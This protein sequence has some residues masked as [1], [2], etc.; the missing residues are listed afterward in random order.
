[1]RFVSLHSRRPCTFLGVHLEN[2]KGARRTMRSKTT[3]VPTTQARGMLPRNY[4]TLGV[5]EGGYQAFGGRWL[6]S[7]YF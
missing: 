2:P 3:Q 6:C 7:I 1:M 4:K 5:R